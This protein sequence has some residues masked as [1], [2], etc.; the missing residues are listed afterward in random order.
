MLLPCGTAGNRPVLPP[1]GLKF[2]CD[3]LC[4]VVTNAKSNRIFSV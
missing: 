1:G 2:G 4:I 3:I